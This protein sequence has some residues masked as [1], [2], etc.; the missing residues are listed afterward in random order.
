M[1]IYKFF[2]LITL[3]LLLEL[4]LLDVTAHPTLSLVKMCALAALIIGDLPWYAQAYLLLSVSLSS[5]FQGF[6]VV[7]D[8]IGFGGVIVLNTLLRE[9]VMQHLLLQ[10][11]MVSAA[12]LMFMGVDCPCCLTIMN[13]CA[14]ILITPFLIKFLR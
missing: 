6:P 13:F 4:A 9:V 11:A 5:F 7:L 3:L 8:L 10:S 2:I 14:T 12:A 1:R